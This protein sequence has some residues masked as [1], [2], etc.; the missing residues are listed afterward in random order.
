MTQLLEQPPKSSTSLPT[1]AGH[2]LRGR[3][4][5]DYLDWLENH[6]RVGPRSPSL[7]GALIG[8]ACVLTVGAAALV[9]SLVGHVR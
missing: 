8:I 3:A 4:E 1:S 6:T 5:E 7:A 9:A 2:N